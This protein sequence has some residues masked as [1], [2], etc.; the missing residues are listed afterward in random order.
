VTGASSTAALRLRPSPNDRAWDEL[1][2]GHP[3]GTAFHLSRFLRTVAPLL[4]QRAVLALAEADGEVVGVVPMLI[5][6]LGPFLLVNH[7]VP[8][9]YLGPLLP[10]DFSPETVLVAVRRHLRAW[11]VLHFGLQSTIPFPVPE[12]R[13]WVRDDCVSAIV[14]TKGKDD[15]GLL[16]LL[17]AN[18]RNKVR[19]A[20]R[21]GLTAGPA[22]RQEVADHLGPLVKASLARQDMTCRWPAGAHLRIFDALAPSG[23]CTATAVRRDGELLACS[24]DLLFKGRMVGWQMGISDEGRAS[25]AAAVLAT[26]VMR[27]ARDLGADELDM[28]GAPTPGIAHFKRSLGAELRPRS[29]A[30]WSPPLLCRARDLRRARSWTEGVRLP[31]MAGRELIGAGRGRGSVA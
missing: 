26:A 2:A 10:P 4:G 1:V 25:G 11:P 22:T 27:H 21:H 16:G 23:M 20:G 28:L 15:E 6:A 9:P 8:V 29:A 17:S 13:G 24:M 14:Q 19:R 31:L 7:W 12:C 5:R 18:Q 3:A 30:H